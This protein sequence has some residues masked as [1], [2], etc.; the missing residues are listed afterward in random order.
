MGSPVNAQI[1]HIW[2]IKDSGGVAVTGLSGTMTA[3]LM[4]FPTTTTSESATET[5]SIAEIG[6]TGFYTVTYT[7]TLAYT[8]KG[9]ITESTLYLEY[10]FEDDV[11]DAPST[12]SATNAY[13]T[14]ADV[15]S[16]AQMGDYTGSTTPTETQVLGFMQMRAAQVYGT[17]C[18]FLGSAAPGPSAYA[19][20]IDT[21]TDA[22]LALSL[23]TRLTNALGAAMDAVE[24]AGAGEEPS[25]STRVQELSA[26]YDNA[27]ASLRNLAHAYQGYGSRSSTHVSEGEM[28]RRSVTTGTEAFTFDEST[29]W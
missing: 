19:T 28:S 18:R 15:V 22:G 9:R 20:T 29:S 17:L 26:T 14:E 6:S 16:F 27:M 12:A 21:S 13:C 3:T 11:D 5:V 1:L 25:Q 10:T 7:P 4:R 2:E 23:A 24:A 8:Y